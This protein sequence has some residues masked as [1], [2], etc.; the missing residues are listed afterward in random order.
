MWRQ[1]MCVLEPR[2]FSGVSQHDRHVHVSAKTLVGLVDVARRVCGPRQSE[3]LGSTRDLLNLLITTL[4]EH[5]R[6]PLSGAGSS[7]LASV[8]EGVMVKVLL[9]VVIRVEEKD[10]GLWE[11]LTEKV[12]GWTHREEV[13]KVIGAVQVA[14]TRAVLHMLFGA[15]PD[16]TDAVYLPSA[17]PGSGFAEITITAEYLPYAW[18]RSLWLLGNPNTYE[19]PAS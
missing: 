4:D 13:L 9:E 8:L 10:V 19:S 16:G 2:T 18:H 5:L 3:Y 17:A 6:S 11:L 15:V 1:M 7:Q 12:K 14:L